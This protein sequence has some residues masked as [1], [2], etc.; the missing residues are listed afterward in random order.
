VLVAANDV[1][2]GETFT[3]QTL[4]VRD[5]PRAYVEGR[6]IRAGDIKDVLGGRAVS[7]VRAS[8]AVLW[9]DLSTI[10]ERPRALSSLVPTGMRAVAVERGGTDFEGLLQA[11]DHVDVLLTTAQQSDA[12]AKTVTLLQNLLVLSIGGDI[13]ADLT[14]RPER[15]DRRSGGNVTVSATAEQAQVLIQAKAHGKLSLIVRNPDDITLSEGMPATLTKDVMGAKDR[16]D[17]S[18]DAPRKKEP[19]RVQ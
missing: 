4:A 3:D 5:L 14:A 2:A 6:H 9:T 11:G 17:W 19:A 16:A 15:S 18:R 10:G 12:E 1:E 8:E 7:P 13:G